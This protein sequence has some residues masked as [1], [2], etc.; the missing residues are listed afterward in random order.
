MKSLADRKCVPCTGG[1]SPLKGRALKHLAKELGGGWR[2]IRQHHLEKEYKFDNFKQALAFTN[3]V[4]RLAEKLNHHPDIF[5]AWGKVKL[6]FWT[7]SIHGLSESDFVVAA[8]SD[9]LLG[10]R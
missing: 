10:K 4:G 6:T 8:K 3:K 9:R 2:V 7:H 1:S 5:L